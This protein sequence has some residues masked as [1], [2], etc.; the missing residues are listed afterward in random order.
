MQNQHISNIQN[1][2]GVEYALIHHQGNLL[3]KSSFSS[4]T[5]LF[6]KLEKTQFFTLFKN[7]VERS[8]QTAIPLW[9]HWRII[10]L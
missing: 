9:L 5:R 7:G 10:T 3:N 2:D 6:Q 4:S 8:N 1:M